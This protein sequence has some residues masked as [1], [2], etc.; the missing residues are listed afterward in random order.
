MLFD[1][2]RSTFYFICICLGV[3]QAQALLTINLSYLRYFRKSLIAKLYSAVA[4]CSF[5]YVFWF[6]RASLLP[7][8]IAKHSSNI[9]IDAAAHSS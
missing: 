3:V 1:K 2:R 5:M 7:L 8:P 6:Q 9:Y 4:L